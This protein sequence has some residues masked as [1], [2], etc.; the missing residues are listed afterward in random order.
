MNLYSRESTKKLYNFFFSSSHSPIIKLLQE[1][2]ALVKSHALFQKSQ[3]NSI[4]K[5]LDIFFIT[6]KIN[7]KVIVNVH[8]SFRLLKATNKQM[9]LLK[10][11]KT[12]SLYMKVLEDLKI[13]LE[14]SSLSCLILF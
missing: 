9:I 13:D 14:V 5:T 1:F 4:G 6:M 8:S 7:Q 3:H 2:Y 10:L 12:S 11:L